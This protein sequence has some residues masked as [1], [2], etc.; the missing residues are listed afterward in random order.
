M[1]ARLQCVMTTS[2]KRSLTHYPR[3]L[4]TI[5]LT[6]KTVLLIL[7]HRKR[8]FLSTEATAR[9]SKRDGG[10]AS[11]FCGLAKF[12]GLFYH[13]LL[14]RTS[15]FDDKNCQ[16]L[17]PK[18]SSTSNDKTYRVINRVILQSGLDPHLFISFKFGEMNFITV[19]AI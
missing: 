6:Y 9:W 7:P 13:N 2:F 1:N 10:D 12:A 8:K 5:S 18:E 11:R 17:S 15:V 4:V 3:L 14:Y 19:E 16:R